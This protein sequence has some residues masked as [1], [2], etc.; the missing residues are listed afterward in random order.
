M[1]KRRTFNPKDEGSSPSGPT[2]GDTMRVKNLKELLE[3]ADDDAEVVVHL[4]TPGSKKQE[5]RLV[6]GVWAETTA[7]VLVARKPRN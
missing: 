2:K 1:V 6:T 7:F 3:D 5:R 4:S